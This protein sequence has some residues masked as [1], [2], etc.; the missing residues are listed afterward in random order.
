MEHKIPEEQFGFRNGRSTIQAI[1]N[2][3]E[4]IDDTLRHPKG[5]FHA[6]FIDFAKAFDKLNR[7]IVAAKLESITPLNKDLTHLIQNILR[8]NN[9]Q[10]SDSITM[11]ADIT[12]TNG[13]LQGD[14][15]SPLLFN[16]ATH[17]VVQSIREQAPNIKMYI[18]ADDMVLGSHDRVELQEATYA[19]EKWADQNEL[20]INRDKTEHMIFRKGG[21]TSTAD[22][23]F[24]KQEP[25]QTVNHV[26]YLGVTLQTTAHSFRI[27]NKQRAT[28]A[29]KAIHDI[30][31]LTKLSLTTAMT[32]FRTKIVP[33]TYIWNRAHMGKTPH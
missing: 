21:K 11:S 2:L 23:I 1:R 3:L 25:L 13:V 10:I 20:Q 31:E 17:D 19:I 28:A 16:I 27:H 18:Y 14:P 8:R 12:Q 30:R 4:D 24:M 9:V 7:S 22:K 29:T 15:L 26:K 32:I 5:K 33:I 6:V